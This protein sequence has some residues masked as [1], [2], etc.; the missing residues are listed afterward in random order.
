METIKVTLQQIKT[1]PGTVVYG[2]SDPNAGI[3][4]QY[5]KKSAFPGGEYPQAI[6]ITVTRVA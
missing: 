5:I 2:T 3:T 1:T 6:E 4:Q